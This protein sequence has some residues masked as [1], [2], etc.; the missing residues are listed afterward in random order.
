[1]ALLSWLPLYE[2]QRNSLQN[3]LKTLSGLVVLLFLL[4]PCECAQYIVESLHTE[5]DACDLQTIIQ[6]NIHIKIL[7]CNWLALNHYCHTL[8]QHDGVDIDCYVV[9]YIRFLFWLENVHCSLLCLRFW[10]SLVHNTQQLEHQLLLYSLFLSFDFIVT[11]TPPYYN[12]LFL[13]L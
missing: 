7:S 5:F 1:V 12:Q 8:K 13:F 9:W 3:F 6:F 4:P 2:Y 10:L 11:L